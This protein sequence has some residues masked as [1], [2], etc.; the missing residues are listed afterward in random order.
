M[1][2][3]QAPPMSVT[4]LPMNSCSFASF[5]ARLLSVSVIRYSTQD[6]ATPCHDL[7]VHRDLPPRVDAAEIDCQ[8]AAR[9]KSRWCVFG[10]Q[11]RRAGRSLAL[12][13]RD[14]GSLWIAEPHVN[15]TLCLLRDKLLGRSVRGAGTRVAGASELDDLEDGLPIGAA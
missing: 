13:F 6:S 11:S 5:I 7:P 4:T 9:P 3:I 8:L 14:A 2:I 1:A 10:R 12:A 15:G